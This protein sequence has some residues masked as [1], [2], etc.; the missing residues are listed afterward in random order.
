LLPGFLAQGRRQFG[1]LVLATEFHGFAKALG[2]LD[3][4]LASGK[5]SFDL[6]AGLRRQLQ[7]QILGE[8]RKNFLALVGVLMWF[9]S[10]SPP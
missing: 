6:L 4:R 1:W 7:I 9:H 2:K 10:S 5:M 8:Q 3:T